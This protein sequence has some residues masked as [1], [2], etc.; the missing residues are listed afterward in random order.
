LLY[1]NICDDKDR[2]GNLFPTEFR[3]LNYENLFLSDATY[4]RT[5]WLEQL[6]D[7]SFLKIWSWAQ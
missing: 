2:I 5:V 4:K 1:S 7:R 3:F 6:N